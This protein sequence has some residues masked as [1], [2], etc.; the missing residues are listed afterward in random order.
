MTPR[1]C[2]DTET[3][4]TSASPAFVAEAGGCECCKDLVADPENFQ[5]VDP[6][7]VQLTFDDGNSTFSMATS[8]AD[9]TSS[10]EMATVEDLVPED[11]VLATNLTIVPIADGE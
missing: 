6:S 3:Q 11:A 7:V 9:G 1:A 8:S 5:C 2:L 4:C 10:G